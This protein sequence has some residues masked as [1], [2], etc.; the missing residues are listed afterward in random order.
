MTVEKGWMPIETAPKDGRHIWCFASGRSYDCD[1]WWQGMTNW[2]T[3]LLLK[4][5]DPYWSGIPKDVSPTHWMP[6]PDPP[7]KES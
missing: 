1:M 6:L 4:D 3:V 7:R 5:Q 2:C